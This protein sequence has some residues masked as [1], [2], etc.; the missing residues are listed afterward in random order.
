MASKKSHVVDADALASHLKVILMKNRI[1]QARFEKD[2]SIIVADEDQ[3]VAVSAGSTLKFP[4]AFAVGDLKEFTKIVGHFDGEIALGVDKGRLVITQGTSKFY[5]QLADADTIPEP[6]PF[7]DH[8]KNLFGDKPL[9]VSV[10][11]LAAHN[12]DSFRKLIE[13]DIVQFAIEEGKVRARSISAT[14]LHE[15]DVELGEVE[16][17]RILKA[18]QKSMENFKISGAALRDVLDG[19]ALDN[20]DLLFFDFG[21]ALRIRY[22]GGNYHF[23]V[24][25]Q[26]PPNEAEE[27]GESEG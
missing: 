14:T 8:E 7:K 17:E 12:L 22:E 11:A 20:E 13:A 4:E 27:A 6:P 5:Y 9:S 3:E 26:M 2:F 15:A 24:S 21:Q 16:N 19:V 23:L 1:T 10:T 18:H 25:T